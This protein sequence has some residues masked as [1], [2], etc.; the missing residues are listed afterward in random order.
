MQSGFHRTPPA[1]RVVTL[2][3]FF[4][5]HQELTRKDNDDEKSNNVANLQDKISLFLGVAICDMRREQ[6]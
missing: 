3:D 5:L 4:L 1:D 2:K 6:I